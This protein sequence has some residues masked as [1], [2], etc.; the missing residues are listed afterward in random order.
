MADPEGFRQGLNRGTD[1]HL[2]PIL[3]RQFSL[4]YRPSTPSSSCPVSPLRGSLHGRV[5][6]AARLLTGRV[7]PVATACGFEGAGGRG[8]GPGVAGVGAGS[9]AA[10]RKRGNA[11]ESSP[12]G[13]LKLLEEVTRRHP[14]LLL[15]QVPHL[16]ELLVADAEWVSIPTTAGK[17]T[18]G[19]R[20]GGGTR[21]GG[22]PWR[23]TPN[24]MAPLVQEG[25][26]EEGDKMIHFRFWGFGFTEAL[27]AGVLRA[28]RTVDVDILG[29]PAGEAAGVPHLW[30]AYMS[31]VAI[32]LMVGNG[33]EVAQVADSLLDL[34]ECVE[35]HTCLLANPP[36]VGGDIWKTARHLLGEAANRPDNP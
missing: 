27:W 36:V 15:A 24:H 5:R 9:L 21:A 8:A 1:N 2:L 17:G 10:W 31:L 23:H 20:R 19:G 29:G 13:P 26:E 14:L 33:P 11:A 18:P 32:Q 12:S 30:E 28:V 6:S 35:G 3:L 16:L 34:L 7:S 25:S 4:H 22:H